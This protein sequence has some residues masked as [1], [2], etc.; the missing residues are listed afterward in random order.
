MTF[1]AYAKVLNFTQKLK[2]ASGKYTVNMITWSFLPFAV[3]VI[4]NPSIMSNLLVRHVSNF[5]FFFCS[6]FFLVFFSR[7]RL[8]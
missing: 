2:T 8:V 3:N 6:Y 1:D 7:R 5:F 4:L